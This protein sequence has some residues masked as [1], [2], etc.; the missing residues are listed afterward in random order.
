MVDGESGRRPERCPVLR[1]V[2]RCGAR[3]T[4]PLHRRA[5]HIRPAGHIAC[6][7]ISRSSSPVRAMG[8]P[9]M[10]LAC[11]AFSA[12]AGICSSRTP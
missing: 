2:G 12:S 10:L 8:L 5:R 4:G 11:A 6:V 7:M 9:F 1:P 3:I